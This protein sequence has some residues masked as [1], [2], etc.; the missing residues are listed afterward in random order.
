MSAA[1]LLWLPLAVA[2]ARRPQ[3]RPADDLHLHLHPRHAGGQLQPGVR[4][5]RAAVDVPRRRVRDRGLR[6]LSRSCRKLRR[7]VLARARCRRSP[8]IVVLSI[9]RR[10]RSASSSGCE[11]SISPSSRWRSRSSRGSSCLNWNSVTNGTLGLMVLDKP[12]LWLPGTGVVKIDGTTG[13]VLASAL[14]GLCRDRRRCAALVLRSWIGRSF[15]RDPAQRGSGANARH[16]H[17]SATSC[18]RSPSPTCWRRSPAACSASTSATSSPAAISH[19]RSRSTSS[20]WCCSA[21]RARSSAPIVGAFVLTG[22]AARHRVLGR[23][24]G[25]RSTARS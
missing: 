7:L 10:L 22:A 25:R 14:A 20:R 12:T 2:A 15:R 3:Q 16:Q 13:V 17:R 23:A 1:W 21:A 11:H 4:L 18:C 24:A 9:A 5:H 19:Q 8:C 6:H